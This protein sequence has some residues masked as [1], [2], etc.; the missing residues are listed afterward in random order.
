MPPSAAGSRPPAP[1]EPSLRA[2]GGIRLD[3]RQTCPAAGAYVL[4]L[5]V[6]RPIRLHNSRHAGRLLPPGWYGYVGRAGRGLQARVRRHSRKEKSLFWNID[7][8]TSQRQATVRD[9]WVF[10][11][12]PARECAIVQHL[13]AHSGAMA[14]LRG[15]GSGDCRAGCPAHLLLFEEREAGIS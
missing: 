5:R 11:E 13:L 7:H 14:P 2:L 4:A 1:F 10:P 6:T 8:L 15:F 12:A 3:S 9:V